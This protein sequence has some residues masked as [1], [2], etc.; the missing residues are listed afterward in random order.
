VNLLPLILAKRSGDRLSTGQ[1][2]EFVSSVARG[3]SPDYQVSALLMAIFCRGMDSEETVELTRAMAASGRQY[4][5][6]ALRQP[7]VDKHSTGG[8]GDKVSLVLA[9]LVAALGAAVPMLSG[10]GLGFTG[11]TLDKLESIPGLRTRLDDGEFRRQMAEL[12]CAFI[13]QSD[14]IAPADR[15]L[16]S[17]RDVTGTVESLPLIVSSILS[18]K[19]AAGPASLVI[20]LKVGRGAFMKEL[21][22]ARELGQA[23]R[24]TAAAFGRRCSVLYTRMDA[25]LGFCVGNGPEVEESLELLQGGG[26]PGLRDLILALAVEMLFLARSDTSRTALLDE[27]RAALVDGRALERFRAVVEA[28][29]GRIDTDEPRGGLP[30]PAQV[31]ELRAAEKGYLPHPDAE[32]VGRLAVALGAGRARAEDAV[33]PTAGMRFEKSWGEPVAAGEL[34]ARV[35]GGDR[36]RVD[37]VAEALAELIRPRPRA[38]DRIGPLIA[39][40]DGVARREIEDLDSL[41]AG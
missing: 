26:E 30:A 23:L 10:R 14:G 19:I 3:D 12:G 6:Y 7:T 8:V 39:F 20:D 33:D 16:Y 29:G 35:M 37:R 27:C 28:Q 24:E 15:K 22:E 11:G 36:G 9:P 21:P 34:L 1:I 32:A 18:K 17:L 2:E 40:E 31:V 25:P 5:W 4:D 13:G 41:V 38:A